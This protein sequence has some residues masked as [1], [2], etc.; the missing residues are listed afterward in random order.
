MKKSEYEIVLNYLHEMLTERY[1][2]E[3]FNENND[4]Y[5]LKLSN[6]IKALHTVIKLVENK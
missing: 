4:C 5:S 6:E 1:E 2:Q 3:E